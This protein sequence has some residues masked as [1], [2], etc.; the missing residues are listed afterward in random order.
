MADCALLSLLDMVLVLFLLI[1]LCVV[2]GLG[3]MERTL[4]YFVVLFNRSWLLVGKRSKQTRRTVW[5]EMTHDVSSG[6]N[7]AVIARDI[8]AT[9]RYY[10]TCS[11]TSTHD[12]TCSRL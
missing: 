5:F 11:G 10:H 3:M 2:F 1:F 7:E 12:G 8:I 9:Y 6:N 4:V